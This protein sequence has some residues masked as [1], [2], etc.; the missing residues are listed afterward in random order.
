MTN[1]CIRSFVSGSRQSCIGLSKIL[2]DT[3]Y[4]W[5]Y[6]PTLRYS[7]IPMMG[8]GNNAYCNLTIPGNQR[9]S[10]TVLQLTKREF[11][12][13]QSDARVWDTFFPGTRIKEYGN[14]PSFNGELH[15]GR[16]KEMVKD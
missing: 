11:V 1:K 5:L 13:Q 7:S 3:H 15:L 2:R 12:E 14:Y 4:K 10:L 9:W 8:V 16:L 6:F